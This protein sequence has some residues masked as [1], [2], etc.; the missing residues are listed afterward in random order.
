MRQ[1]LSEARKCTHVPT[2]FCVGCVIV[3]YPD[4]RGIVL[5]TGYSRELAGNTHAEAN[6]L[7]KA[8]MLQT[9]PGIS[10]TSTLSTLLHT[11]SV[12]TT[13]EPCS[14]RTSGLA[15][16][17]N[18]LVDAGVKEVIIGVQEPDDFVTCEGVKVLRDGGVEVK[19]VKGLDE[20]CL[21]V[22]R[23]VFD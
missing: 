19:W 1:A 14:V 12:Y 23:G 18:A 3:V 6:A 13:L 4:E 8:R 17:A 5:S 16:C 11:A 20:E 9:L 10:E 2:A 7:Q 21:R 22:A 15:P